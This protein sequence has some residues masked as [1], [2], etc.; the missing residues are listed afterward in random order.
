[1][2]PT[3]RFALVVLPAAYAA[4]TLTLSMLFLHRPLAHAVLTAALASSVVYLAALDGYARYFRGEQF[5]W[6]IHPRHRRHFL[7]RRLLPHSLLLAATTTIL[8]EALPQVLHGFFLSP[9]ALDGAAALA[10]FGAGTLLTE[11]GSTW[12]TSHTVRRGRRLLTE[13]E[14]KAEARKLLA[15]SPRDPGFRFGPLSLPLEEATKH[16]LVLGK[17]G[18]GKSKILQLMMQSVLPLVGQ[19]RDVRA[20]VYDPKQDVLSH[21]IGMGI[22]P[23]LLKILN[24]FDRRSVAWDIAADCSEVTTAQQIATIL[25]P[26]E[27]GSQNRYFSDAARE[28]LTAVLVALNLGA[29]RRF[30]FR[31]VI[32]AT[33]TKGALRALLERH[34]DCL[35]VSSATQFLEDPKTTPSI[36]TTLLT[37]MNRYAPIAAAWAHAKEKVSL[38]D[39]VRGEFILVLGNDESIRA[40]LDA[41]NRVLFRRAT[42]LIL[43]QADS[44]QRKTFLFLD[45]VRDAGRL[46]LNPILTKGR[47]KGACCVLALQDMDGF[48]DAQGDPL[49]G[50]EIAAQC[51]NV[52]VFK[53]QSPTTA[54]Y[55]SELIGDQEVY[56]HTTG[57]EEEQLVKREAVMADD[58]KAL[59]S[60]SRHTGLLGYYVTSLGAYPGFIP[61]WELERDLLPADRRY[62]NFLR[63]PAGQQFLRP[64]SEED[65]ARLGVA[66]DTESRQPARAGPRVRFRYT[67]GGTTLAL[68]TDTGG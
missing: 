21:L 27:H 56:D 12:F 11:L 46:D 39:W 5:G 7:L 16:S 6:T 57:G 38:E 68:K 31:D 43:A 25:I 17:T 8:F 65:R 32:L 53:L 51:T 3:R 45:E 52:A 9:W 13:D 59:P 62:A 50:N 36:L 60:P 24:P 47:S 66:P 44:E 1:M 26:E 40:P 20:L 34:P 23:T 30:E 41:I 61:G 19:G 28:L 54:R 4:T 55:A 64:W 42:E 2:N 29:P 10:A 22:S 58:I 37:H 15:R 48:R 67:K 49:R 63:R 35:E 33:K 14:A 18:A